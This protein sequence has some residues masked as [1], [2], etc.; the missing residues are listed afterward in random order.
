[1]SFL[2][3]GAGLLKDGEVGISA[4]NRNYK[5]RMG[6]PLAQAYLASPGKASSSNCLPAQKFTTRDSPQP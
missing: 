1:M 4:T 2:G 6:S 3:L 5:G